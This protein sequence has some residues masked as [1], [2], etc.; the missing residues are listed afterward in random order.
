MSAALIFLNVHD[1]LSL[2]SDWGSTFLLFVLFLPNFVPENL[3]VSLCF[4]LIS[5]PREFILKEQM[6]DVT[7]KKI[8]SQIKGIIKKG[9]G[10]FLPCKRIFFCDMIPHSHSLN[11]VSFKFNFRITPETVFSPSLLPSSSLNPSA[12]K[13]PLPQTHTFSYQSD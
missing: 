13:C 4:H 3:C 6:I 8:S 12:Y 10:L 2:V 5:C 7:L 1:P 11:K 9:F